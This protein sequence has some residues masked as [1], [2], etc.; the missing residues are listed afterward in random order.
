MFLH[1]SLF[2]GGCFFGG[3]RWK[4]EIRTARG[5]RRAGTARREEKELIETFF[6]RRVL[7]RLHD[8]TKYK[9]RHQVRLCLW[10]MKRRV[11]RS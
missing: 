9:K 3:G 11:E 4:G 1:A 2:C 10:L 5:E 7:I 8:N 6:F